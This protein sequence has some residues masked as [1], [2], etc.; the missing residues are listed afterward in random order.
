LLLENKAFP[1]EIL[2]TTE[3]APGGM[4]LSVLLFGA[5]TAV[6]LL[7]K[8][9]CERLAL[10]PVVGY[11][12]IGILLSLAGQWQPL[13][14]ADGETILAFLSAVGVTILLFRVGIESDLHALLQELPKAAAIWLPNMLV[15]G[16]PGYWV[17]HHLLGYGLLP[18]LFVAVAMTATSVGV[19]VAVWEETGQMK[20]REGR[21]L[22]D[23]AEL[24]DISGIAL[25]ALLF[26][27][28]PVLLQMEA[29]GSS[30]GGLLAPLA[31]ATA[32]FLM[33]FGLFLG[34][35]L[36]AGRFLEKP[37]SRLMAGI[38]NKALVLILIVG[39][40]F[41]IAGSAGWI[42]LS[43]PIGALFAG[44]LLSPHRET[45]GVEP[46]YRSIYLFFI[47]Y[48]FIHIGYQIN[49]VLVPGALGVGLILTLVAVAGKILGTTL[50]ARFFTGGS[51]ALLVGASMVPRAEIS[52]VVI[53]HGR[54]LGDQVMP[55]DL[56]A[57]MVLVSALTCLGTVLFLHAALRRFRGSG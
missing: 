43:L 6:S 44:L 27:L 14:D 2:A 48:F 19:S 13:L 10:P 25:M 24:D 55:E 36:F 38:G 40:G 32:G 1:M 21:L 52:M 17:T 9:G 46:F 35:I 31:G 7:M 30:E 53:Q 23:T 4:A 20:R 22:L 56:Y 16:L 57:A 39:L 28:A 15:S 54:Q 29:S 12:S 51:G 3:S 33:K 5:L 45:Y 8:A 42:G 26:S 18:G 11:L 34:L 50:P 37:F 49:P 47:P 41:L